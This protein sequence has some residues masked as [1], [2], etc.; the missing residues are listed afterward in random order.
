MLDKASLYVSSAVEIQMEI[1]H[2]GLDVLMSQPIFNLGDIFA[3][4]E[5]VHGS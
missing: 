4:V 5:Q 3:P 2:S 1:N